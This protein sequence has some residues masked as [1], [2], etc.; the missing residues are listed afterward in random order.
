MYACK[1]GS[2]I[3]VELL[4]KN[5]ADTS[6]VNTLGDSALSIAQKSTNSEIMMLI[7]RK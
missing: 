2:K 4:L 3:V 1:S 7:A 5:K 6:A